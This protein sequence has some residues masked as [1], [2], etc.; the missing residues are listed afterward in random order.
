M[1]KVLDLKQQNNFYQTT[2][3]IILSVFIVYITMGMALGSLPTFILT[4]L[5]FSSFIVGIVIGLQSVATLFTRAYSGKVSDTKG[6]KIS[7][8]RGIVLISITGIVY[9]LATLLSE[10]HILSLTLLLFA[11]LLHGISESL[12]VTGALAWG[13]GLVG[14][15]NSG[16][17]MTWNGIAMYAGIAL[18]APLSIW[19]TKH[20]DF[21]S[22]YILMVILPLFGWLSTRKLPLVFV[23][24]NLERTPFYKVIRNISTQGA[25]LGLASI[26]FGCISSFIVLLFME[27]NWTNV[28]LAFTTFCISYILPRLF[29]SSLP[30][31]YGGFM[32]TIISLIIEIAGQLLIA[33]ASTPMM[34]IIGC[35]LTGIGFSLVFPALSSV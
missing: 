35:A 19:L 9:L 12:L 15:E 21:K 26:A 29:L 30:D 8:I 6:P 14:H 4:Q 32:V 7:Q 17:V 27:K 16:K 11:R 3:P 28:S 22:V 34:V 24:K 18:G 23:D 33:F 31:K 25:I 13:I 5:N 10:Y 20:I 1:N 2:I